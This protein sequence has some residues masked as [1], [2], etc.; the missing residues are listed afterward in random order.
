MQRVR[1]VEQS[2]YVG[3][4]R[5]VFV[6]LAVVH[7]HPATTQPQI[8]GRQLQQQ[9][10]DGSIFEPHIAFLRVVGHHN[11]HRCAG[12][13]FAAKVATIGHTGQQRAVIN[14]D[15]FP[16]IGAFRGRRHQGGA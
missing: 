1:N 13:E 11:G 8:L 3:F 15:K 2:A 5:G 7:L 6:V 4:G 10:S 14:D 9:G 16:T 12:N